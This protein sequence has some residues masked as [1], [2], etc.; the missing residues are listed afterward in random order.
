MRTKV[1]LVLF[2][3]LLLALGAGFRAGVAYMV[4]PATNPAWFHHKACFYLFNFAIEIIVVYSYALLRFD[5]RFHIPNGSSR[6]GDYSQA[7]DTAIALDVSGVRLNT[8]S[9]ETVIDKNEGRRE[10]A[11][12][13]PMGKRERV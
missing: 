4:R 3:S 2:T 7:Q 10:V 6:P 9:E 1:R 11:G 8:G 5:H 12:V 13:Q